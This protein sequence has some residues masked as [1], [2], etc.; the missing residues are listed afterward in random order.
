MS[1][2]SLYKAGAVFLIFPSRQA[3]KVLGQQH[4]QYILRMLMKMAVEIPAAM[5][6]AISLQVAYNLPWE[7]Q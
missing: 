5:A 6:A 2:P 4:K 7:P 1:V 3:A